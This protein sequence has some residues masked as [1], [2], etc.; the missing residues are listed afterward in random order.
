M[1]SDQKGAPLPSSRIKRGRHR[2]PRQSHQP[3]TAALALWAVG[4]A[5]LTPWPEPDVAPAALT[6]VASADHSGVIAFAETAA[7]ALLFA[8]LGALPV[9]RGVSLLRA[10]LTGL[11][12]STAIELSQELLPDRTSSLVDVLANTGGT[13]V[14]AGATLIATLLWRR[15]GRRP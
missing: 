14:G 9:L 2:I 11:A 7:N 5:R 12:C 8:P 1:G 6:L 3:N 13:S 4:T 10:V 15:L